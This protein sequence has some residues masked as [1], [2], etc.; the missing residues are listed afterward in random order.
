[1]SLPAYAVEALCRDSTLAPTTR[2]GAMTR[3]RQF[4][5]WVGNPIAEDKELW[6]APRWVATNRDWATLVEIVTLLKHARD[7]HARA[8][9]ALMGTCGMRETEVTTATVGGIKPQ[10]EGKFELNFRG[11]FD[12]PRRVPL[13][14]QAVDALLPLVANAGPGE[15]IYPYKRSRLW[16]DVSKACR[17]GG[18][19]HLRPHDLRRGFGREFLRANGHSPRALA[20]LSD[21]YGHS[22]V[23]ETIYY[24]GLDREAADSGMDAFSRAIQEARTV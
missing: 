11:K 13:S 5:R 10:P 22:E 8:A 7:S 3:L 17:A 6:R 14:A 23:S 16:N 1:M 19:R 20:A 2:N 24:I 12:K 4:L 9:I 18:I 15:R 21:I